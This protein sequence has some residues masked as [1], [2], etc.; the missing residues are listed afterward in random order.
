MRS[1]VAIVIVPPSLYC[2]TPVREVVWC[3]VGVLLALLV[4]ACVF[5]YKY[6]IYSARVLWESSFVGIVS[7]TR[8]CALFFISSR[9]GPLV[10]PGLLLVVVGWWWC[11]PH[12]R[13]HTGVRV[14]IATTSVWRRGGSVHACVEY[15]VCCLR[16]ESYEAQPARG[17]LDYLETTSY[18][19]SAHSH[20]TD[21]M[22]IVP[23]CAIFGYYI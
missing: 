4:R 8:A 15:V 17:G 3:V 16:T 9:R 7:K 14:A 2:R 5:V 18:L 13:T 12:T 11:I 19:H 10:A 22:W 23:P 21:K 1:T 20:L 6:S